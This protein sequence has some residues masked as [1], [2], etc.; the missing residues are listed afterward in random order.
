MLE[1]QVIRK[2]GAPPSSLQGPE[3]A[4]TLVSAGKLSLPDALGPGAGPALRLEVPLRC[5]LPRLRLRPG[6]RVGLGGQVLGRAERRAAGAEARAVPPRLAAVVVVVLLLVA[7]AAPGAL[8]VRLEGRALGPAPLGQVEGF[9]LLQA[10]QAPRRLRPGNSPPS[11]T[12][13]SKGTFRP[14]ETFRSLGGTQGRLV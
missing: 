8:R 9:L 10:P 5:V 11:K 3:E 4:G 12:C 13:R 1:V 14:R 2:G 7:G 6:A